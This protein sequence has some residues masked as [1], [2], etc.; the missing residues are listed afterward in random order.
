MPND[1]KDFIYKMKQILIVSRSFYPMNS[2]RSFRTTE[3]VKEFAKQGHCVTLITPK[4]KEHEAFEKEYNVKIEDLGKSKFY[5]LNLSKGNKMTVALKRVLKRTLLQLFEYPGIELMFQVRNKLKKC[6]INYDLL[7]SVAVPF[8]I[9]WGVAWA[10]TKSNR[11]AKTWVA[12]CGD[13]YYY[14][15]HDSF[16]K[17]FYFK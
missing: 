17:L 6:Q 7:I 16:K 12:D 2:P 11:V 10:R 1:C 3:L 14:N 9:H 5:K 8:P 13:P 15:I 4:K